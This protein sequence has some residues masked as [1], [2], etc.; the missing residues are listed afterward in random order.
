MTAKR[1]A[2]AVVVFA[3]AVFLTGCS[4][5]KGSGTPQETGAMGGQPYMSNAMMSGHSK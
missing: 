2:F 3:V 1:V 5:G 4:A